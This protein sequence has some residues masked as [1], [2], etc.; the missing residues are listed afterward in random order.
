LIKSEMKKGTL[1]QTPMKIQKIIWEYFENLYSRKLKVKKKYIHFLAYYDPKNWT[2]GHK[3]LKQIYNNQWD[4]DIYKEPF[5][6]GPHGLT[7]EF[8]Q[9]LKELMIML[10]TLFQKIQRKGI[11]PNWFYEASIVLILKPGKAASRKESYRPISLMNIDAKILPNWT[12]QLIIKIIHHDQ[13]SFISGMQGWYNIW[14]SIII[15][16]DAEK[17]FTKFNTF[18]W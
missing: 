16:T 17:V 6:K 8:Y 18:L 4:C 1:Q 9:T 12:Q 5:N 7:A 14:K 11:L 2:K 15:S 3:Q 13:V 10:L